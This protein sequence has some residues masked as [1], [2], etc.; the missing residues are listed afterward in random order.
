MV[1]GSIAF[2][3]GTAAVYPSAHVNTTQLPGLAST[4]A[5][6]KIVASRTPVHSAMPMRFP[7]TSL[8][9]HS[10]VTNSSTVASA[11]RS[12]YAYVVGF[13]TKPAIESCHRLASPGGS[14][15]FF[16]TTENSDGGGCAFETIPPT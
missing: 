5:D 1:L 3:I 8:L 15:P 13:E 6:C 16:V 11:W 12:A 9:T 10:N 14:I 4:P 7:P 2:S